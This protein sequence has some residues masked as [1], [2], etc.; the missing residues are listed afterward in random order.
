MGDQLTPSLSAIRDGDKS[1]DV[2]LMMEVAEETTYARHHKKK[3]AFIFAAMR[4]FAGEMQANGWHVDYVRLDASANHGSFSDEIARS[5][6]RH[7]P[8]RII[9]TEA[10]E[11]RVLAAQEAWRAKFD[12]EFDLRPDDRFLCSKADFAKWAQGR[13]QLRM[14]YFYRDMRK[15][16]GLLMEGNEPAGGRWNF[17]K[18]NRKPANADLFMPA[19]IRFDPDDETRE[20]LDVVAAQFE[21]NFGDLRPFWFP[22]TRADAER[23]AAHFMKEALPQF[24]DF[25]DAMLRG[26]HFLFHSV[27]SPLI[28]VG[29]LDPLALCRAAETQWKD[30]AAPLN[31]VEGFIRQ[32]IGWREYVRGIYWLNGP[33]YISKNALEAK[34]NLPWMYW[35]GETDMACMAEAIGQTKEEAYAH[36]IQRLMVT[37]NFALLA[38][39]DPRQV[40]EWYLAVYADAFEWVEAPNTIGMSQFADGGLLASKPYAASGAYIDRMSD[41][42]DGCRYNVKQRVGEDAC[43][44]N[45][46]YWN[47]LGRHRAHL[48][49]NPRMSQMYRTYDRF[50]DDVRVAL[51]RQADEFLAH[52]DENGTDR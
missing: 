15:K 14:E 42:C 10:G 34:R 26:E 40:H 16:T 51:H 19:P 2:L 23:A 39:V 43:P 47:F 38:G 18:K 12:V 49:A 13:R 29:L 41:Y 46:L 21:D 5:I 1:R 28:N 45:S 36:H 8:R 33:D 37:G 52:L 48:S 24:G 4:G 32:I 44:F 11:H 22:V 7:Q 17:D 50:S 31:A 35:S 6:G 20:V 27:L 9:T 3:I 25:Q 30:G